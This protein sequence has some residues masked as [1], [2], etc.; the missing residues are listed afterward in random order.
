MILLSGRLI[1]Y[2]SDTHSP[3]ARQHSHMRP[4]LPGPDDMKSGFGRT[5]N[6][7]K[8]LVFDFSPLFWSGSVE[9]YRRPLAQRDGADLQKNPNP[10]AAELAYSP[11]TSCFTAAVRC[12]DRAN[13][14]VAEIA[15]T[16]QF[17]EPGRFA[18]KYRTIFG[19]MPSATLRRSLIKAT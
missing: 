3:Q 17:Q 7:H 11:G 5:D 8:G 14:R 13:T 19:E 18:V 16:H 10:P 2:N 12:G 4:H 9:Y 15:R 6:W 1:E